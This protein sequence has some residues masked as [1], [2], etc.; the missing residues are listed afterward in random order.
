MISKQEQTTAQSTGVI[1]TAL[2]SAIVPTH[3][4][5]QMLARAIR[6]VQ[7]QTYPH[8][9]IVVVDDAS[10]DNTRET[11]EGFDD[12]RIRYVRHENNQG[13]SAARNTGIR[14]ATGEYIAFLDDDDEWEPQKTEEQLKALQVCDVVACASDDAHS[15]RRRNHLKTSIDLKDLKHGPWGGTGVLMARAAVLKETLFDETLPRGQDWDLFIRIAL[16]YEIGYLSKP[17]LKYDGGTHPRFTNSVRQLPLGALEQQFRVVQKHRS[18]F[19]TAW[20]NRQMCQ[21]MLYGVKD[22]TDKVPLLMY[23]ARRYGFL[24]VASVLT[25]RVAMNFIEALSKVISK[26]MKG[27]E[28]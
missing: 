1:G 9:E 2:V 14:V 22:R 6:S 12:P 17:L 4:R 24:N 27:A 11:M 19:G 10:T 5:A 21:G 15:R 25:V 20:F 7:R 26:K 3:N 13:G 8:L 23:T 16:K 18:L 28:N